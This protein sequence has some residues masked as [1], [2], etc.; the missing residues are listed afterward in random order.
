MIQ[1]DAIASL[2]LAASMAAS[3]AAAGDAPPLARWGLD[4]RTGSQTVEQVSGRRDQV[5]YVFNHARFKPDSAPLWRPEASCIHQGCLLF[6]GYST[7]VTAPPLTDAQL[8]RGF[9]LS[10]WVAP[11]AFEWGDGGHYSA[12][13]SQFDAEARQGFSF[14]VYRF[15]TWG[16]KIG[17]GALV[18]DVLVT[19]RKLP[20]DS[21]SPGHPASDAVSQW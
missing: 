6:D 13:I 20:R 3:Q 15:G 17:L 5:N 18:A 16:I 21:W 19:D 10:A 14:G 2:L 9:T 8:G 4:E 11:H 1:H 7:D 12:F